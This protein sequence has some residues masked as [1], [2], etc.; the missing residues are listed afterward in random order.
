MNS[1]DHGKLKLYSVCGHYLKVAIIRG[2]AFN[3]G[4]LVY[5]HTYMC[6]IRHTHTHINM[7]K[8]IYIHIHT[9]TYTCIHILT[10]MRVCVYLAMFVC[11][12]MSVLYRLWH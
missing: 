5:T 8:H 4:N 10:H 3:Q 6:V 11:I 12:C 2:V 9:H 7:Y 1:S